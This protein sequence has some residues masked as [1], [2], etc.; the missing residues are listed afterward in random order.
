MAMEDIISKIKENAN[1]EIEKA[2]SDAESKI[3]QINTEKSKTI[4]DYQSQMEA[5]LKIELQQIKSQSD[6]K[7]NIDSRSIYNKA[8]EEKLNEGFKTIQ[9]NFSDFCK[10]DAY[11]DILGSLV[12]EALKELGSG[13]TIIVNPRDKDLIKAPKTSKIKVDESISGG[14]RALSKDGSMGIDETLNDI[15]DSVKDKIA[16]EFLKFIK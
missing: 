3:Q 13:T 16:I 9:D 5:K 2:N 14:I 7:A 10:T 12:K 1:A 4:S 8:L 6:S 11:K 15:L